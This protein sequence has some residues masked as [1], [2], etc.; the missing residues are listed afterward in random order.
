MVVMLSQL[1]PI[2]FILF[3]LSVSALH[4]QIVIHGKVVDNDSGDGI[5]FA[6]VQIFNT[7][8][9]TACSDNGEFVLTITPE[10]YDGI[11]KISCIGYTN[12]ELPIAEMRNKPQRFFT[13]H[14][15][16]FTGLLEEIVITG[17]TKSPEDFLREALEAIPE[18]FLQQPFNMEAYSKLSVID[19]T[20]AKLYQIESILSIYREGYIPEARNY[21]K[22][23]R[24]RETGV[25]PSSFQ[26][27]DY[28]D[29]YFPYN[30]GFD[31]AVVDQIGWGAKS[32]YTI[33][34]PKSIKK[35][36][37]KYGEVSI[38]DQDTVIAVEYSGKRSSGKI[39][40]AS[41]NLAIVKH[42]I[43]GRT[44]N[45]EIIYKN[46]GGYYFPYRIVTRSLAVHDRTISLEDEIIIKNIETT[47]VV[48][49]EKRFDQYYPKGVPNDPHY[50]DS[51]YPIAE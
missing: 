27:K 32:S 24:K 25:I 43:I 15:D 34:H 7:A 41:N 35:M 37:F 2:V 8:I 48:P 36:E 50:W 9:G 14:L 44:W 26:Y 5:P 51:N 29:A 19:S 42:T 10:H 49:L 1:K 46:I 22:I 20:D 21:Y 39:Y 17:S 4:A 18:N 16:P 38:Y 40:I 12:V 3:V 28:P 45:R 31:I 30:P 13:I 23:L 6:N 11:L 33:F 47:N